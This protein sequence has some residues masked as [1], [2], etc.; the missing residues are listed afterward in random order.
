MQFS[1]YLLYNKS[2]SQRYI[3]VLQ[4]EKKNPFVHGMHCCHTENHRL[5]K[6]TTEHR[7]IWPRHVLTKIAAKYIQQKQ[8]NAVYRLFF[9]IEKFL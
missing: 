3:F 9:R 2:I 5:C 4:C 6:L 8:K 1:I 7:D